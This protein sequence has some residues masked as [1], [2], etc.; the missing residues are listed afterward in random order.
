MVRHVFVVSLYNWILNDNNNQYIYNQFKKCGLAGNIKKLKIYRNDRGLVCPYIYGYRPYAISTVIMV[1]VEMEEIKINNFSLGMRIR[2]KT[3]NNKGLYGTIVKMEGAKA[4][5]VVSNGDSRLY[6]EE[7]LDF[8]P[9]QSILNTK[10]KMKEVLEIYGR[11]YN[12][13]LEP[14]GYDIFYKEPDTIIL[15]NG[16]ERPLFMKNI[17]S[18]Q[19]TI[20]ISPEPIYLDSFICEWVPPRPTKSAQKKMY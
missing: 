18:N 3:G 9:N 11:E 8:I 7:Q 15:N 14:P 20:D 2:V 1:E 4:R 12:I 17:R 13:W 19:Y 6:K 16:N 10:R 5:V